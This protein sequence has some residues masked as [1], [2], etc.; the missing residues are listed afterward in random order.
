MKPEEI[1]DVR[2]AEDQ[3]GSEAVF[4]AQRSEFPALPVRQAFAIRWP[5]CQQSKVTAELMVRAVA[6]RACSMRERMSSNRSLG[7]AE[8]V[9]FRAFGIKIKS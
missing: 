8:G 6:A 4:I 3:I 9:S 1:E 7:F 5:T 2:V